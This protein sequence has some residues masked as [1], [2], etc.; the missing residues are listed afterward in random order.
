M[1]SLAVLWLGLR[2]FTVMGQGS[3]PGWGA[4]T[5]QAIPAVK[6]EQINGPMAVPSSDFHLC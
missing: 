2:D 3:I 6:N 5:L 1:N 4:K